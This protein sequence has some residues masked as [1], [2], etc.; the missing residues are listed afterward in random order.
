MSPLCPGCGRRTR[1]VRGA[2]V[3]TWDDAPW[4]EHPVTLRYVRLVAGIRGHRP[5]T[6]A[7]G[8]GAK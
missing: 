3:R 5:C 1:R 8:G 7:P 4:A 2:K 6:C